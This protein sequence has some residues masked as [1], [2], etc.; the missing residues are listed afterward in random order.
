MALNGRLWND[1]NTQQYID[2]LE[3]VIERLEAELR[4]Q[5]QLITNL[6]NRR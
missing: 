3:R 1:P 4:A 6:R 5:A 2:E